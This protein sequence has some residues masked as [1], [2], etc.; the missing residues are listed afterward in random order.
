[1]ASGKQW[2]GEE[3]LQNLL[4]ELRGHSQGVPTSKIK[5]IVSFCNKHIQD[6]KMIVYEIEKY[7]RKAEHVDKLGGL[8]VLDSLSRQ[9]SKERDTF[10]KRFAI[11]LKETMSF[12]NKVPAQDKHTMARLVDAWRKNNVFPSDVLISIQTELGLAS[13]GTSNDDTDPNAVR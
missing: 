9:H 3:E 13:S 11:R 10:M 6:F 1:M 2:V 8:F 4:K 7:I 5:Q 12:M